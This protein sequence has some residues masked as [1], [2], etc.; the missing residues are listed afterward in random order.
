VRYSAGSSV[1]WGEPDESVR[2]EPVDPR[3]ASRN[4]M[5]SLRSRG[6][7]G[8]QNE[9]KKADSPEYGTGGATGIPGEVGDPSA[10]NGPACPRS[11]HRRYR[12][13]VECPSPQAGRTRMVTTEQHKENKE[14]TSPTRALSYGG[15]P[16]RG[17]HGVRGA[18]R[19]ARKQVNVGNDGCPFTMRF[20]CLGACADAAASAKAGPPATVAS[21]C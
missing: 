11:L 13:G 14:A 2:G 12:P 8:C 9:R 5:F 17:Q 3:T 10:G 6:T 15:A 4:A 20:S 1:A 19:G 7:R 21:V 18:G 16:D